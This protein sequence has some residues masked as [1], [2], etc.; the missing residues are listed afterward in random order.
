[1]LLS[2]IKTFFVAF[3][4]AS[5]FCSSWGVTSKIRVSK[6]CK[7][8]CKASFKPLIELEK[9]EIELVT[10]NSLTTVYFHYLHR[11]T[12]DILIRREF[13][14]I[15]VYRS[16]STKFKF[17]TFFV[18]FI[19]DLTE[20]NALYRRCN[21]SKLVKIK[22]KQ[23]TSVFSSTVGL[24]VFK[25]LP[26]TLV[27]RF[28]KCFPWNMT[29]MRR[30]PYLKNWFKIWEHRL[31]TWSTMQT[32]WT[33][34]KII[35]TTCHLTRTWSCQPFNFSW[36]CY[37]FENEMNETGKLVWRN[38]NTVNDLTKLHFTIFSWNWQ[39]QIKNW[40]L[41]SRIF[42]KFLST[43]HL[44][45]FHCCVEITKTYSDKNFVKATFS[46][47]LISRNFFPVRKNFSFFHRVEITE[48]CSHTLLAKLPW[49]Q[50]FY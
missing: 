28:L 39:W 8:T 27:P 44:H 10:T 5:I 3:G 31:N 14:Q 13:L 47:E 4:F 12:L 36:N 15:Q 32:G 42:F 30:R 6:G 35:K 23:T 43:P 26:F 9:E 20:S 29:E 50:R 19:F 21:K 40:A 2:A 41:V 37:S 46:K 24:N 17:S 34:V 11:N 1:M 49:K 16:N 38:K 25:K 7:T 22:Q 18:L 45:T 33:K 48:I